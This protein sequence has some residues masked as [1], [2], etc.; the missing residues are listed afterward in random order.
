MRVTPALYGIL[1]SAMLWGAS[2]HA[3]ELT[4]QQIYG[5]ASPAVVMV[6]GYSGGS[7]KGSGGTGSII[8]RDGLVLTNAHVV[9]E[10]KTGKPYPKLFAY[11]KPERVTGNHQKDLS[12]GYKAS[13]VAFS[14]PLDLAL[15]KLEGAPA[16]LPVL[17]LGA[18]DRVRIGDRV[19]AIG[20]PEQGGLWTLTTGVISAEFEDF[21]NTK[22]KHVFQTETGLNR[23]N[24]GGPLLDTQGR[25]I[26]VN[27][28]IARLAPDGMPITSISFSLKSGVALAWLRQQGVTAEYASVP[29]EA[30]TAPKPSTPA[31]S[32]GPKAGTSPSSQTP[33][34]QVQTPARP[35]NLDQL[36]SERSKAEAEMEDMM[37]E[38]R[39]GL[40]ERAGRR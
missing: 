36:L 19:V 38:M 21:Q 20:H 13:V 34:P 2:A 3:A 10:E 1:A 24:S 8:R 28:A 23:G 11:V 33:A 39:Q 25:I 17:E 31:S 35:Y 30:P 37:R 5:D 22:G 32:S 40:R 9:V 29:R 7:A 14:Q 6:L 12:R 16:S 26:G 27:T 15:L 4:P 18:S